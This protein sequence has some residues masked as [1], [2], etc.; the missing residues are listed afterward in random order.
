M[1]Q[2]LF[3]EYKSIE[4]YNLKQIIDK[5]VRNSFKIIVNSPLTLEDMINYYNCEKKKFS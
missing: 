4:T 1:N 3:P 2:H 5:S